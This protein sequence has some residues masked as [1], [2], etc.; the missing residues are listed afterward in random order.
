MRTD[1]GF[2]VNEAGQAPPPLLWRVYTKQEEAGY[3]Y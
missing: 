3:S 1:I 2:L